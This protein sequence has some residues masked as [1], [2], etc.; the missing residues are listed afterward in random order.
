[1]VKSSGYSTVPLPS[2]WLGRDGTPIENEENIRLLNKQLQEIRNQCQMVLE[3]AVQ[4]GVSEGFVRVVLSDTIASL[5]RPNQ[6]A[7]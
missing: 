2:N 5:E 1:M 3:E 4:M 6:N 7:N